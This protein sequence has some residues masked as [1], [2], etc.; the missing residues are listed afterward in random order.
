[1]GHRSIKEIDDAM[2]M[3]WYYVRAKGRVET[4]KI[5]KATKSCICVPIFMNETCSQDRHAVVDH[6]LIK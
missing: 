3:K 4:G 2:K 1:M 5:K 6:A